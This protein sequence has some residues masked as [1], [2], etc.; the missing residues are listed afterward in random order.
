MAQAGC[1]TTGSPGGTEVGLLEQ[2]LPRSG[3]AAEA[4]ANRFVAE[5]WRFLGKT[6]GNLW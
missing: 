3:N 1:Y 2:L 5:K 4:A 6:W